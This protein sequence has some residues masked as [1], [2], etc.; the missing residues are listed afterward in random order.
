MIGRNFAGPNR[1]EHGSVGIQ[2]GPN[3]TGAALGV[4]AFSDVAA[5]VQ[6]ARP[7]SALRMAGP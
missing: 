5:P 4:N 3:V 1:I 6:E 2:I 7:G